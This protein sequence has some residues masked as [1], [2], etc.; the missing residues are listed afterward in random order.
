MAGIE[1]VAREAGVSI[2]T[3]S[4]ALR[5]LPFVSDATRAK[6]FAAAAQLN[7]TASPAAASLR[8]GRSRAIGVVV[9]E[10][11]SWFYPQIVHGISQVL[12]EHDYQILLF[13]L[14]SHRPPRKNFLDASM[15]SGRIDAVITLSLILSVE[16]KEL[17][18][19]LQLPVVSLV[20]H[21][22]SWPCIK[23][24]EYGTTRTPTEHLL[25]LGHRRIAYIG[26]VADHETGLPTPD[27]RLRGYRA[28]MTER[29]LPKNVV[30][31]PIGSWNPAT[32]KTAAE[33][34]LAESNSPTAIVCANDE[35][36]YGA[37]AAITAYGLRIPGDVSVTGVDDH[38][39]AELFG[40]TTVAQKPGDYGRT[41]AQLL[42]E[43]L[44]GAP[45]PPDV[46]ILPTSLVIR[47]STS[48]N[49]RE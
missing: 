45:L 1:D 48:K 26:G 40:L 18:K 41:A 33:G 17:I 3:V 37:M 21:E 39:F 38:P 14:V 31:V 27:D 46:M 47:T 49:S 22:P 32:G 6:V 35:L 20:L 4:R 5:G 10:L 15:L 23:I 29:G 36:A 2:A 44:D 7:Y 9:P 30:N 25:T 19:R 43:H 13:D 8:L 34:I 11:I 12:R 24:D 16:E 42:I 28:A